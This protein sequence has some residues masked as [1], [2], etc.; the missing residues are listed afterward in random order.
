MS[1]WVNTDAF[2]RPTTQAP[3][4]SQQKFYVQAIVS[5]TVLLLGVFVSIPIW[6]LLRR[7]LP[8]AVWDKL[9]E[10]ERVSK[11]QVWSAAALG[12]DGEPL[13]LPRRAVV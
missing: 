12:S 4:S 10:P 2:P 8:A 13:G 1:K 6:N 9:Q 11:L 3:L 7:K 5:P